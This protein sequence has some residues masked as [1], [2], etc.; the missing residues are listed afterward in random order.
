[1]LVLIIVFT[2]GGFGSMINSR[3][4]V[5]TWCTST[6]NQPIK[7]I[8]LIILVTTSVLIFKITI[9]SW[10]ACAVCEHQ[11]VQCD[12]RIEIST[13]DSFDYNLF[14]K[15]WKI[16]KKYLLLNKTLQSTKF[17]TDRKLQREITRLIWDIM[18]EYFEKWS[19][20]KKM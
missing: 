13:T 19:T 6:V 18:K 5:I 2:W 4:S 3:S 9:T 15:K 16:V 1:M 12:V 17:N 7:I 20:Q 14:N 10:Y 8:C 11:F